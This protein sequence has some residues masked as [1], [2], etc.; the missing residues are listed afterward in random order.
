MA[1]SQTSFAERKSEKEYA[2]GLNSLE[3]DEA[4]RQIRTA[5]TIS[6][7]PELFEKLYLSPENRVKGDLRKTFGNPTPLALIGFLISLSPLACELMG[8]RESGGAA[9]GAQSAP[10]DIFFGGILLIMGSIGEFLLGNTFPFVVFG[11][12]GA[13]WLAYGANYSAFYGSWSAY[14][15][16]VNNPALGLQAP[17]YASSAGFLNVALALMCFVFLV[18]SLRT[19][20]CFV[21]I[22]FTLVVAF[23][24]LAAA[25]WHAALGN[26][27]VAG[28]LQVAAGAFAFVTCADGWYLFAA[29][30][31][32]ALDFPFSLPVG[33]LSRFIKSATQ[34]K[35]MAEG[36]V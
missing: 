21:V 22:F 2:N 7:S 8:W 24:C 33:D 12:F 23:S 16:D 5:G 9:V 15:T 11:S 3:P 13:F 19:N 36:E 31:L 6:L 10:Q 17:A 28:K 32:A 35:R 14:S 20:L 29:I 1:N 27:V 30:M 25:N 26:A 34:R 4:L 18:C